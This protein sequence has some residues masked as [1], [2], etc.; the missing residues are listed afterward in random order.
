M[1]GCIRL[2]L[3]FELFSFLTFGVRTHQCHSSAYE[4]NFSHKAAPHLGCSARG[5]WARDMWPLRSRDV[6]GGWVGP[7]G[8]AGS[9]CAEAVTWPSHTCGE[10][11]PCIME[12]PHN[13]MWKSH[14][15]NRFYFHT[16]A[17]ENSWICFSLL[18]IGRNGGARL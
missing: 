14:F 1:M 4:N 11:S 3:V 2:L 18:V 9:Q 17:K 10:G 5:T 16:E 6:T 7:S 8:E 13:T 15:K 12:T